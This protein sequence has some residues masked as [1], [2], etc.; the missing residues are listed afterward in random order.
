MHV[1]LIAGEESGDFIGGE[2]IASLRSKLNDRLT[3]SGIGGDQ[4]TCAGLRSLFPMKEL[5]LM[6]FVEILPHIFRLKRRIRQ[7]VDNI[8]QQK[9]Q[10]VITIDSP[11]FNFRVVRRLRENCILSCPMVHYVAPTVWAYKPER[12]KKTAAL[13]DALLTILPF[14]P[15]YFTAHGLTTYFVG[16]PSAWFWKQT[17]DGSG[18]RARHQMGA[19]TRVIGMMPG[20]RSGELN[21]HLPIFREVANKLAKQYPTAQIVMPVRPS[22]EAMVREAVAHWSLPVRLVV[23]NTEK[24]DAFAA[25]D[26]ALAKS[27]TV[28]LEATLAG[29]PTVMAYRAHPVTAWLVRRMIQIPHAHL[30]NIMAKREVIPEF[31]QERCTADAT[32]P[33]LAQLLEDATARTAQRDAV[34][35]FAAQLGQMATVSPSDQAA[36][37][38]MDIV[39][40]PRP[41][42]AGLNHTQTDKAAS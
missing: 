21:R 36:Q 8:E 28:A 33:A 29:I 30:I 27:G 26:V 20:S 5:S 22:C 31:I 13:Y 6:G 14:E 39:T 38:I 19:D 35:P 42:S 40:N 23:G 25:C 2:L 1:Y 4:M 16:H 10:V 15:P 9:P 24:K 18:F 32:Y 37:R 34:S 12:A 3:V 11:G 41:D 7:T 17:G